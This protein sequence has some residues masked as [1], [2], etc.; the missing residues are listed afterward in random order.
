MTI[1][2]SCMYVSRSLICRSVPSTQTSMSRQSFCGETVFLFGM[3]FEFFLED[4]S[5]YA[6]A[7][8]GRKPELRSTSIKSGK[9]V[10]VRRP[11]TR[12]RS[13]TLR[14]VTHTCFEFTSAL[15][16]ATR[17]ADAVVR[18]RGEESVDLHAGE[19][20]RPGNALFGLQWNGYT[21]SHF[22]HDGYANE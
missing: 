10:S 13:V 17:R 3:F 15:V 22:D 1:Y 4:H 19:H 7:K 21:N 14:T 20:G 8:R 12:V 5:F 9:V 2:G 18:A 11:C 16:N 6:L